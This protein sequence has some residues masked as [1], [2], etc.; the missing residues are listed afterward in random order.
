MAKTALKPKSFFRLSAAEKRIA[1]AEDILNQIKI[2][3]YD[4]Q[5]GTWLN[6]EFPDLNQLVEENK[7]KQTEGSMTQNMLLGGKRLVINIPAANCTCCAVGAACASAIRLY[8]NYELKSGELSGFN[9]GHKVLGKYFTRKQIELFEAAFE[10]RSDDSIHKD[11]TE[12]ELQ[13]AVGFGKN[14]D[15]DKNRAEAIFKNVVNNK[16]VFVP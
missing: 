4:I 16:G 2:G 5:Q 9:E 8:N 12:K 13:R 14:Y 10:K 15:T 11:C 6:V 7:L 1:I 3:Q